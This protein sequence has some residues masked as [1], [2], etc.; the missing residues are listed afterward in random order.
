MTIPLPHQRPEM[1]PKPTTAADVTALSKRLHETAG[2]CAQEQQAAAQTS[3]HSL[4]AT[5][6]L[7]AYDLAALESNLQE[8]DVAPDSSLDDAIDE[9]TFGY[10]RKF[11]ATKSTPASTSLA[12][13]RGSGAC[14]NLRAMRRSRKGFEGSLRRRATRSG[15]GSMRL[16]SGIGRRRSTML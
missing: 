14:P 6:E 5:L 8:E 12:R 9:A 15:R 2:S 16:L 10:R 3:Q 1:T 7:T 13:T 11:H 4:L